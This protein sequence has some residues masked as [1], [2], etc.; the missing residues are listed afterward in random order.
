MPAATNSDF[1]RFISLRGS[2]RRSPASSS[3]GS[4]GAGRAALLQRGLGGAAGG[5]DEARFAAGRAGRRRRCA[6]ER[7]FR[8]GDAGATNL[9]GPEPGSSGWSGGR[10][11]SIGSVLAARR[12]GGVAAAAAARALACGAGGT[13]SG[14]RRAAGRGL[15]RCG[16]DCAVRRFGSGMRDRR[17]A[18]LPAAGP[19]RAAR[20]AAQRSP[21]PHRAACRRAEPGPLPR[22]LRHGRAR[23]SPSILASRSTTSAKV[24]C[25]LSTESWVRA[26]SCLRSSTA[27]KASARRPEAWRVG[28]HILDMHQQVAQAP[29]DR[30][31]LAEPR[32]GSVQLLHQLDDAVLQMADRHVV[33]ARGLQQ[34]DLVGQRLHQRFQLRR[35][36]A[37]V[38]RA[39]GQRVG[40]RRYAVLE[41]VERVRCRRRWHA[42][43]NRPFRPA[44]APGRP[45]R[46]PSRWRRYWAPSSAAC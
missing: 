26:M 41:I 45:A 40:D 23:M 18:S 8:G 37:A 46:S 33:A 21:R 13:A 28:A 38:L 32:F 43:C 19:A 2:E 42:R 14:S 12:R 31:E 44:R 36:R 11:G 15:R 29:L 24:P 6:A 27:G 3:C 16:A 10:S 9:G 22:Q 7:G 30:L 17:T 4:A 5:G 1:I 20:A 35:H 34:L 39:L 25:T